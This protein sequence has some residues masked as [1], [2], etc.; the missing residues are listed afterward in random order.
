[1]D[2][3]YL[4]VDGGYLLH[5]S[6][7]GVQG[8]T[9]PNGMA[10]NAI[11]GFLQGLKCALR[12]IHPKHVYVAWDCM[13]GDS[14]KSKLSK[15]YLE[16]GLITKGYKSSRNKTPDDIF[17][18]QEYIKAILT[19]LGI[20]QENRPNIEADDLIAGLCKALHIEGSSTSII[21]KVFILSKDKD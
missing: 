5:R 16:Q 21:S 19:G 14:V 9:A 11:Y 15:E 6:Y 20:Y 1:M 12:T 10:T 7:W 17:I 2:N 18:Q 13:R 8:L 3:T 4:L